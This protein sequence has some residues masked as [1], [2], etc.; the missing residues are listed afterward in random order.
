MAYTSIEVDAG[1]AAALTA[2]A[3]AKG[4]TLDAYLR[5]LVDATPV[6]PSNGALSLAE[7][8]RALDELS[9]DGAGLPVLPAGFCRTEIYGEH[10]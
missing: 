5:S 4:M 10:D 7:F 2:R 6:A 1:I 9:A 3:E 8:D